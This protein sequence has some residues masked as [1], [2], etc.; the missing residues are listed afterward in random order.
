VV[1]VGVGGQQPVRLEARAR[2]Q[3]GQGVELVR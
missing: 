1:E 3:A 2:E